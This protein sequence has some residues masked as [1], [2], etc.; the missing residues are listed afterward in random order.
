MNSA[1]LIDPPAAVSRRSLTPVEKA[2][3]L[4]VHYRDLF[5]HPLTLN[6][7]HK[8]LILTSA[9]LSDVE[10]AVENLER[11]HLSRIGEYITWRGRELLAEERRTRLRASAQI[12][13]KA[14]AYGRFIR[15]IPFIRMAGVTGSLAVNHAREDRDDI[16]V[17]CIAEPN[18]VWLVMLA[19]KALYAYTHHVGGI[20]YVCP[21]TCLA[22]D[23]LEIT[24]HNLYMAH[25]IVHIVP[26]W[27]EGLYAEFL[28]HN[29]WVARFLPNAYAE[30]RKI[31]TQADRH[32]HWSEK[33]LPRHIGD[34][35]NTSICRAGVRKASRFYRATH[36]DE[37]LHEARTP[38]RYMLPGLGY[39][40]NIYRRFMHGHASR[41][42]NVF[43]RE[44]MEAAFG[45]DN[46]I[47]F[48][49]RLDRGFAWKYERID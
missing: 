1:L 2:V 13:P 32:R 19:L 44:E 35:L 48:D 10:I 4:T 17:F 18:R 49:M 47:F 34:R 31:T 8:Y 30:Q 29:E 24:T 3:L 43:S 23:Q 41:F 15:K 11:T 12:W 6:E 22:E 28:R 39:T 21:N 20:C 27:G 45:C 9:N 46:N 42:A 33:L 37:M 36:T 5:R 38:H 16:D 25:Q 40:G 14:L 26:M 7:L